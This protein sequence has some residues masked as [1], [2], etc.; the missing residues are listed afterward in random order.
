MARWGGWGAAHT[1]RWS[2]LDKARLRLLTRRGLTVEQLA[3]ALERTEPSIRYGLRN[4]LEKSAGTTWQ[5][6]ARRL[7]DG[8]ALLGA[9][10]EDD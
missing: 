3:L 1:G 9:S 10:E 8:F 2:G 5:P 7:D 4:Y 6:E